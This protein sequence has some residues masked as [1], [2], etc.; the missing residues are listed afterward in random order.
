MFLLCTVFVA[1]AGD[2]CGSDKL[3]A[4]I[5][6]GQNNHR[7][8]E[9]T[10]VIGNILEETGLFEV[11][12]AT[13]PPLGSPMENFQPDF[14][15]YDVVVS[16][17]NGDL[18]CSAA[19]DSFVKYIRNGGGFVSIHASDNAFPTWRE[20]NEIIGLGGWGQRNEKDGPYV[21]YR[22]G[23]FVRDNRPGRGGTHG[24]RRPFVVDVRNTQHPITRGL[25]TQWKH[26]RDELYGLLRGPAKNLTVLATAQSKP[27]NYLPE[28]EPML[29]T[30]E[31]G[32]GR[33]F[34]TTLGHDVDAMRCVG[35]AVTLQRGAEW[36]ATGKV[37]QSIPDNFPTVEDVSLRDA[38]E[39][40]EERQA[41]IKRERSQRSAEIIRRKSGRTSSSKRPHI[42]CYVAD[43]FGVA[44]AGCYGQH[45]VNTPNIDGLAVQG[46]RFTRAFA[47]SPSCAPSRSIFYTGLMSART[48]AHP[49]HWS[50]N[51]GT[52]SIAHYLAE[53][54]YHVA[55]FNKVH[56]NPKT[57]FPFETVKAGI[58]QEGGGGK[59]ISSAA[60]DSWLEKRIA[61]HPDQPL[62]L[63]LCDN[64]THLNWPDTQH[65]DKHKIN[66]PAYLPN[67]EVTRASL[68]RYFTE[69]ELLDDRVGECIGVL[70]KH[71]LFD[72]S[73]FVFTADQGPAFLHGKWNLYDLGIQVPFIARWPHQ[74]AA[75]AVSDAM[76][77]LVDLTPTF[78]EVAGGTPEPDLDGKSFS[79]CLKDST[80]P[81]REHLFATH[82]G[83]GTMN[84]Y[85]CRAIRTDRYK[86]IWN[87]RSDLPYSTHLTKASGTDRRNVWQAWEKERESNPGIG[88]AMDAYTER[89]EFELYDL[90]A[91]P[92]ELNNLANT[93]SYRQV[94][95][96]LHAQLESWMKSQGDQR[97][98]MTHFLAEKKN[99]QSAK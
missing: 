46:T 67:S 57:S 59:C 30:V 63:F 56:V 7:W 95:T 79:R 36:A 96:D 85:P 53:I 2:V 33:S 45:V 71:G 81:H 43:D 83:D 86:F 89:L 51:D 17:F 62:C 78:V 55:V 73:L 10:P 48:G 32:K 40:S 50:V 31:Y 8:L 22:E 90:Q 61:G 34:Q 64:N 38:L 42:V 92:D 58:K 11:E 4:L 13:S 52:K 82:T 94:Q 80:L 70:K 47:G 44:D 91:D 12:V 72:D 1:L 25:P 84:N 60:L 54:G 28:H 24:A 65:P 26:A 75:G 39:V 37:T 99:R 18:W 77:S 20:Y 3:R 35:F 9:T 6:D 66:I 87:L 29:F 97:H 16:N 23:K 21:F 68:A 15:D 76:I 5:V 19:R 69:V 98:D 41:A 49:N 74:V 27:K 88:A 14:A 93:L